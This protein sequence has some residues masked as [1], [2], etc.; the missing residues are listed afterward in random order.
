M[1]PLLLPPPQAIVLD[2]SKPMFE[3]YAALFALRNKGSGPDRKL[4][5]AVIEVG[6]KHIMFS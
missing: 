1:P 5:K 2:E 4:N 6:G 3:R